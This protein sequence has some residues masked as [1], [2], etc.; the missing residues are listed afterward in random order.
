MR[1]SSKET[2]LRSC[3][4]PHHY[5][6]FI[7][8]IGETKVLSITVHLRTYV[9][10]PV[11]RI[12]IGRYFA[13]QLTNRV[14]DIHLNKQ[15]VCY[16]TSFTVINP[17][18][19]ELDMKRTLTYTTSQGVEYPARINVMAC[20]LFV[21]DIVYGFRYHTPAQ[22]LVLKYIDKEPIGIMDNDSQ[23]ELLNGDLKFCLPSVCRLEYERKIICD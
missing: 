19:L 9:R 4:L 2:E 7:E 23:V 16:S 17:T 20:D 6:E 11:H 5:Q 13:N 22:S 8:K 21:N 12:S 15:K 18:A 1:K 10:E 3:K 14:K